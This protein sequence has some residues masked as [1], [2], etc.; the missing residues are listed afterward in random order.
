MLL[1]IFLRLRKISVINDFDYFMN[2]EK[3]RNL[4]VVCIN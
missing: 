4:I 2:Q 1:I 3:L